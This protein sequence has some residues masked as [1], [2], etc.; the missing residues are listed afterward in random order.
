MTISRNDIPEIIPVFAH[1]LVVF[2]I[3][4]KMRKCGRNFL[5]FSMGNIVFILCIFD[6]TRSAVLL[7]L[8]RVATP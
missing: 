6:S 1:I 3:V 5:H 8:A 2:A 7:F 4:D